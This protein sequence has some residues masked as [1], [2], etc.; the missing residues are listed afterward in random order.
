MVSEQP[1]EI[2]TAPVG[3]AASKTRDPILVLSINCQ[4]PSLPVCEPASALR[5]HARN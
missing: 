2:M 4:A 3:I 5:M 1:H